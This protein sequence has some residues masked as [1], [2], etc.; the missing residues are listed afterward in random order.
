MIVHNTCQ[1]DFMQ[2]ISRKVGIVTLHGYHN[3]GNKLQ[4]Y[5]AKSAKR[6]RFNGYTYIKHPKNTS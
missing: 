1:R 6:S 5:T 4:N 2:D 3:Y